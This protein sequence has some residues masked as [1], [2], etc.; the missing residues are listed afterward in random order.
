MK[1]RVILKIETLRDLFNK[2]A[3]KIPLYQRI[4][5][6][7]EEN[8]KRL[9][10]D[11][12]NYAQEKE[13]RMGSI[14]LQKKD[15]EY[16]IIDG[17]QRLVTLTLLLLSLEYKEKLPLKKEKFQS[18]EAQSYI[19]YNKGL[20]EQYKKTIADELKLNSFLQLIPTNVSF[21]VLILEDDSLDL[22][23]TFFSNQNS[24][25]K[26]LS[27]YDLLKAH[28]LRYIPN[29]A[30][31]EH[32]AQRWDNILLNYAQ[33]K[34]VG[35]DEE[36]KP[37]EYM[38]QT[39]DM[40]QLFDIYLFRLRKWMRKDKVLYDK[41]YHVKQEFEAA[42]II[43]GIPPFG[44]K[45]Y[46]YEKI[47]G[48]S[49]FF[50]YAHHFIFKF[51]QFVKTQEYALLHS[52]LQ[53]ESRFWYRNI[54]E[55]FLFAYFLKFGS[56]YLSEALF[57]VVRA[58]SESRYGSK[59]MSRQ[60]TL[61]EAGQLELIMMIDQATSPTFFLAEALAIPVSYKNELSPIQLRYYTA[62]NKVLN[63]LRPN[64]SD[65]FIKYV[66]NYEYYRR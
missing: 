23:Y 2:Y 54:I 33:E 66:D 24:R 44:E 51:E 6:W 20:I 3:L 43:K 13:Y 55:A 14:I 62:V 17:Q 59:K 15:N 10:N 58:I 26:Q 64:M 8:V 42:P 60:T 16:D 4:Y 48:G 34:R 27:D 61:W 36:G 50:A 31:A 25:G 19:A 22:A 28:H 1:N 32:L 9:L 56:E 57:C 65:L 41:P 52:E 30:E 45:F 7:E 46:Y 5:C 35:H 38:N 63:Q 47:Q 11:L 53:Y 49:H 21:S 12:E 18:S 37:V 39:D 40:N 29:D